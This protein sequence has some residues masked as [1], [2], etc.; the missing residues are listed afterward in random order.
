MLLISLW[1][2]TTE[3]LTGGMCSMHEVRVRDAT[4]AD[5][6]RIC[7]IHNQ[8]IEDRVATLDVEPH[9]VDEQLEWF[10]RHGS[11]HPVVVAEAAGEIIGWAS[12]NPFSARPAYRLV[13]DLSVYI[14]RGW[15]GK[16]I[17]TRLLREV[18]A[19]AR[20]LGYHKIVLSAFPFNQAGMRL[21]EKF[22]F[23]TVGIYQEQGLI[24][25]RWVDTIIMEKLL[26]AP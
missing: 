9:T 19:R 25:G 26:G 18:E 17:G 16:G 7:V 4:Q 8:G 11:R 13:A 2:A 6:P 3:M 22:G 15:R 14:D 20:A 12:L 10:Q 23:R 1:K 5:V 24:D 21:Y